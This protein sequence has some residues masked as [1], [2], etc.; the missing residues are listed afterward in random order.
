MQAAFT[1]LRAGEVAEP[2]DA[3]REAARAR[4]IDEVI[5]PNL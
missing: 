2:D 5:I 1:R 4:V 3:E